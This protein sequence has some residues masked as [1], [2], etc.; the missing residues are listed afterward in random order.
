MRGSLKLYP[1][2]QRVRN[3]VIHDGSA[4]L[5]AE[6]SQLLLRT[7]Y[8][9]FSIGYSEQKTRSSFIICMG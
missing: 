5:H 4:P 3:Q 8:Y 9:V 1:F 7:F 2:H 6:T